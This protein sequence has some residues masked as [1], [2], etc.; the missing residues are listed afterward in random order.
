[1]LMPRP[2]LERKASPIAGMTE[3]LLFLVKTAL[4][5][6]KHKMIKLS[7]L[8]DRSCMPKKITKGYSKMK[9]PIISVVKAR[10]DIIY[11]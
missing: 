10:K 7:H 11:Y 6:N 1:M 3:F 5:P 9:A 2:I 8:T 4:N